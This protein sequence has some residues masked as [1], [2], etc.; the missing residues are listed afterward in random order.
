MAQI[1][2][3][4]ARQKRMILWIAM[5]TL[6]GLVI[7]AARGVLFPYLLGLVLAYLLLPLVNWLDRHM[8]D[9]L[10][11]RRLA[12]PLSILLTYLLVIAI[13]G[14]IV[15]F[16]V[17]LVADQVKVLIDNWP[18]LTGRVQDWGNRGWGWYNKIIDGLQS[19]SPTWKQTVETG[20]Q[21]LA[22]EVIA[23]V[24][25]GV[26]ATVRTVSSTISFI[27]GLIVIPFWLF[28]IL[29]DESEVKSGTLRAIPQ[30]IRADV[31]CMARLI[32]DVLS[33]YIRGQLLLVLFVGG[34]AIISLLVIG[35]PFALLLGLIAGMFELLPFV[36]PILG[37]IPAVLVALLSD[38]GSAIWVA[39]SFFTIQQVENLI[40]VPR[41]SGES[42]KLHPAMVM[43]VLVIGN[44]LAGF[45]G[46]LVAVPITAVLRD[47]FKYLYLRLLDVPLAPDEAIAEIRSGKEVQL[48][49]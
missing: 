49:V 36:G 37:A 10:H 34:M 35:V 31:E 18:E 12:R 2:S 3:L 16:F 38:P 39:A 19:I 5:G 29:H 17:P 9:R 14:T 30:Q 44:E 40:L 46:M 24:Q 15:A 28:Y 33:A 21:N 27:I 8:P 43:V 23:A 6:V 42:V 20:L 11:T 45:L 48:G 41:I 4:S 13:V 7:W 1:L 47:V 26:V 25:Q 32:D 22:G